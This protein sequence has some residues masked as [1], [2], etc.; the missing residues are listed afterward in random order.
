MIK[1]ASASLIGWIRFLEILELE[2]FTALGAVLLLPGN[3]GKE[4]SFSMK[5][6]LAWLWTLRNCFAHNWFINYGNIT[7]SQSNL[8]EYY[9]L[10]RIEL[11]SKQANSCLNYKDFR[12]LTHKIVRISK[13]WGVAVKLDCLD[14]AFIGDELVSHPLVRYLNLRN[15]I[16]FVKIEQ[17]NNLI[18]DSLWSSSDILMLSS[19]SQE[20][21]IP[22]LTL[23]TFFADNLNEVKHKLKTSI[24]IK[25]V[26]KLMKSIK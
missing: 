11:L 17:F 6:Q 22:S 3:Q 8:L 26:N 2:G 16:I 18:K 13:S 14:I 15:N 4:L 24:Q 10:E 12:K 25:S 19:Y 21:Y 20:E 7:L 9:I 1:Q 5:S 23:D